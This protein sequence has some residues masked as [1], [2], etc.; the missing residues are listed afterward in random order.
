MKASLRI[1]AF[2]GRNEEIAHL[3]W[4]KDGNRTQGTS[5]PL[6]KWRTRLRPAVC[7]PD[8]TGGCPLSFQWVLV[9]PA[10]RLPEG[11]LNLALPLQN[12]KTT[13]I[14][15]ENRGATSYCFFSSWKPA[16][17]LLSTPRCDR[18][19]KQQ[20]QNGDPRQGHREFVDRIGEKS[21][22]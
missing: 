4:E 1:F 12:A 11:N 13:M 2:L 19:V 7:C 21:E 8:A 6:R 5:L 10:I 16:F 14:C 17:V 3:C 20:K 15:R 18:R 9:H 22:N